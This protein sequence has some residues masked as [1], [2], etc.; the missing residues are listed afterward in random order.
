M[1]SLTINEFKAEPVEIEGRGD[2]AYARG[3]FSWTFRVA[4]GEPFSDTGKWIA[5]W[6]R[7]ADGSWLLSHDIWDSDRVP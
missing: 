7:Q 6:R 4:E 2:L 5:I 3:I 1:R